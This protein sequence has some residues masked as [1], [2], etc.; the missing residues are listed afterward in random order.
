MEPLPSPH[1]IINTRISRD[2][3]SIHIYVIN[4]LPI[5]DAII[6][7]LYFIVR[8][9]IQTNERTNERSNE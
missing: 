3:L 2:T 5:K 8:A 7:F 6:I 4:V 1:H 9:N